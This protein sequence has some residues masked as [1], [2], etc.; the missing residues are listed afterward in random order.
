M[1]LLCRQMHIESYFLIVIALSAVDLAKRMVHSLIQGHQRSRSWKCLSMWRRLSQGM[2][3]TSSYS[4]AQGWVCICQTDTGEVLSILSLSRAGRWRERLG[5]RAE[6]VRTVAGRKR[7]VWIECLES[8]GS[9][10]M[11]HR[12][13]QEGKWTEAKEEDWNMGIQCQRVI[14]QL[15]GGNVKK[16]GWNLFSRCFLRACD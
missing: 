7:A 15:I 8:D 16:L 5:R 9:S 12:K 14:L 11:G 4:C 3:Q 1:L 2:T 10:Q 13:H 6:V